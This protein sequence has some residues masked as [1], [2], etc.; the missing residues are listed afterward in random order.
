MVELRQ[1][2]AA[3]RKEGKRRER[4][5]REEKNQSVSHSVIQH[6]VCR[7]EGICSGT[8][9]SS[10]CTDNWRLRESKC[11]ELVLSEY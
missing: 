2:S 3:V 8:L 5:R 7:R 1:W 11:T 10:S 4:K 6:L 9:C